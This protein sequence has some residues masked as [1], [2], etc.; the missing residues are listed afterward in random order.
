MSS[1]A[2]AYDGNWSTPAQHGAKQVSF[3][4]QN[5]KDYFAKEITRDMMVAASAYYPVIQN[6]STFVNL[7][8]Y[9][10]DQTH[11]G[12]SYL[13]ALANNVLDPEGG[14]SASGVFETATTAQHDSVLTTGS[15]AAGSA[16]FGA[17]L[18]Y[19]GRQFVTMGLLD[20]G[21]NSV[22]Q[23]T[24]DLLN[25]V[26][27][28]SSGS[29]VIKNVG[30]GW[31][32]CACSGTVITAGAGEAFFGT[33]N[34]LTSYIPSFLGVLGTGFYVARVTVVS[35]I[36][37]GYPAIQTTSV[38]RSVVCPPV[39]TD[40]DGNVFD[41][42]AFL[43]EETTPQNSNLQK[44]IAEWTRTYDR[45]PIEQVVPTSY[46]F[47][48]PSYQNATPSAIEVGTYAYIQGVIAG[49]GLALLNGYYDVAYSLGGVA[50]TPYTTF[51]ATGASYVP[52]DIVL[53]N[54]PTVST[55]LTAVSATTPYLG[56][57]ISATAGTY[58]LLATPTGD[59]TSYAICPPGYVRKLTVNKTDYGQVVGLRAQILQDYYLPG[60]TAGVNYFT[61]IPAQSPYTASAYLGAYATGSGT[62]SQTFTSSGTFTVPAGVYNISAVL[63]GGTTT[64]FTGQTW[65]GPYTAAGGS[66]S[67]SVASFQVQP[68]KTVAVSIGA[69]TGGSVVI[70]WSTLPWFNVLADGLKYWKGAILQRAYT[71]ALLTD[72]RPPSSIANITASGSWTVPAGIT[73]LRRVIIVGG[74]G[75]GGYG[76][77]G[78]G[79]GGGIYFLDNVPVTPAATIAVTIG[80][81]GAG[82]TSGSPSGGVGGTSYF[83]TSYAGGGGG[84]G[85]NS[86]AN[87]A[88][89]GGFGSGTTTAATAGYQGNLGQ[90]GGAGGGPSASGYGYGG[91]CVYTIPGVIYSVFNNQ[92]GQSGYTAGGGGGGDSG[93]TA[94]VAGGTGALWGNGGNGYGGTGAGSSAPNNSG[95]GGG[96]GGT[97]SN[98]GAGGSGIIVVCY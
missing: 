87:A 73:V 8:S 13:T 52:G 37:S 88:T 93:H 82:G 3:P 77:G 69:G 72:A 86:G 47:T 17:F 20:A 61:D 24:F 76:Q 75:G 57:V 36:S 60:F 27:S 29:A 70:S 2:P 28:T 85:A 49:N 32:W 19:A 63:T 1:P 41:P 7:I 62:G 6:N 80:A 78:G 83:G 38:T 65:L 5:Q 79:G 45:I 25:G 10:D 35:G 9:S 34:S 16:G 90:G 43:T 48:A 55:A 59:A 42:L 4:L 12:L 18:K 95:A 66:G 92:L 33:S 51:T 91:P 46:S 11:W 54:T 67:N 50:A 39:D 98:G 81:G 44:G 21:S 22:L 26:L 30:N 53:F 14:I 84:G 97:T 74:G 64:G 94:N 89:S 71:Q 40:P 58:G 31:Y 23:S 68:G 96:G 15:L 56:V